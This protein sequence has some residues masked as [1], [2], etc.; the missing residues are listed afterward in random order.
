M[1][2]DAVDNLLD[3][4]EKTNTLVATGWYTSGIL[5]PNLSVAY[6]DPVKNSYIQYVAGEWENKTDD[7]IQIDGNGLGLALIKTELFGRL[8]YPYFSF[9][10]YG[11]RS[12]LSEDLYFFDALK[13][14][15]ETSYAVK[16]LKAGHIKQ[17]TM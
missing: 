4:L 6:Y 3:C 17:L 5:N 8:R 16:S 1:P 13:N 11:N 12:V 15:G 14:I 7:Y 9:I 2:E 10:E